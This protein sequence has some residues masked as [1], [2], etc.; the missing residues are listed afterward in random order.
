MQTDPFY[1]PDVHITA[2]DFTEM[3]QFLPCKSWY[4]STNLHAFGKKIIPNFANTTKYFFLTSSLHVFITDVTKKCRAWCTHSLSYLSEENH[5]QFCKHKK[6]FFL[7][8]F[9]HVFTAYVTKKCRAWLHTCPELSF[10]IGLFSVFWQNLPHCHCCHRCHD[11]FI[12][13]PN[14]PF[15]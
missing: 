9:L 4:K 12:F 3:E 5:S 11:D 7:T 8:S 14:P 2:N 6:K 15:L 1:H 13:L 10:D